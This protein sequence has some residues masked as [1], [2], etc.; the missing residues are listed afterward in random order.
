MVNF[1]AMERTARQWRELFD[2]CGL[3]V[4]QSATY[5]PLSRE[6]GKAQGFEAG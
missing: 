1:G 2:S 3:E 5:N 4:V 6:A